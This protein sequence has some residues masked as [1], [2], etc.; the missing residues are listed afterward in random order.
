MIAY[1]PILTDH[2]RIIALR[3]L[4]RGQVTIAELAKAVGMS[5]QA[6]HE[7]AKKD[8]LKNIRQVRARYVLEL[9]KRASK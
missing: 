6:L 9:W 3:L 7:L 8:G 4:W 2:Q 5:R 1:L